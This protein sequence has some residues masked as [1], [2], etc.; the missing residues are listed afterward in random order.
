MLY[1]LV[2]FQRISMGA[3]AEVSFA[4]VFAK[5]AFICHFTSLTFTNISLIFAK[6]H[7]Q[8]IRFHSNRLKTCLSSAATHVLLSPPMSA[9]PM[10]KCHLGHR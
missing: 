9:S 6:T 8:S 5:L 3:S 7:R 1:A 4:R 10:N 2:C